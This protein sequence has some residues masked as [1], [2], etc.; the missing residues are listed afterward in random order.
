MSALMGLINH[1][2]AVIQRLAT[3]LSSEVPD[4]HL[5]KRFGR[6]WSIIMWCKKIH[7][8]VCV[9]VS[10]RSA[11]ELSLHSD[12]VAAGECVRIKHLCGEKIN[13]VFPFSE[14]IISR[15]HLKK[16]QPG[17]SLTSPPEMEMKRWKQIDLQ[18]LPMFFKPIIQMHCFNKVERRRLWL[19]GG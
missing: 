17:V 10:V 13:S 2:G 14:L 11:R 8:C 12:D 5:T 9:W 19:D 16:K 4:E 15:F 18:Q 3:K 6:T 7:I 1:R